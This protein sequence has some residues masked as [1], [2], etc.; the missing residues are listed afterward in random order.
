MVFGKLLSTDT[1]RRFYLRLSFR[2]VAVRRFLTLV[3]CSVGVV[4]CSPIAVTVERYTEQN[5]SAAEHYAW[6]AEAGDVEV[7]VPAANRVAVGELIR[8]GIA[9]TL[10]R[11][12]L[13]E[14]PAGEADILIRFF[15]SIED[16]AGFEEQ[17]RYLGDDPFAIDDGGIASVDP[18]IAGVEPPRLHDYDE[19]V[20][21]V[22]A[23]SPESAAL[24]W[25]GTAR[26]PIRL[27]GDRDEIDRRMDRTLEKLFRRFPP[28]SSADT[29]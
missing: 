23:F 4:A 10:N 16:V 14:S 29:Q 9:R 21:V 19:G 7:A 8:D 28:S 2:S 11:K 6:H 26:S 27:S 25:R 15:A 22:E 24:I 12:G 5:Y 1:L 18:M 17:F 20:L 3:C 13:T